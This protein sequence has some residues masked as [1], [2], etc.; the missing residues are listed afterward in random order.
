M[1]ANTRIVMPLILL[2]CVVATVIIAINARG[3]A[4]Q[5]TDALIEA[6]VVTDE[7]VDLPNLFDIPELPFELNKYPQ[8]NQLIRDYYDA[9]TLGDSEAAAQIRIDLDELGMIRIEEMA[10]YIEHY[11]DIEI[12]TKDGLTENSYVVYVCHKV[13]FREI[14]APVPGMRP[15]YVMEGPDGQLAIKINDLDEDVQQYISILNFQDNFVDLHNKVAAEFN[16]LLASNQEVKEYIAYLEARLAEDIGVILSQILNP[17]ITAEQLRDGD[18][19]V[20]GQVNGVGGQPQIVTSFLAKATAVVNIR[21]SDSETA[22][23]LGRAEIGQEFTV[24]EQ[25]GNG[26]SKISHQGRDAFIKSEYLEII[27]EVSG[28]ADSAA[29]AAAAMVKV[30]SSN[31]RIRSTAS[32]SGNVLGTANT[33]DRFELV[34]QMTNGWTQIKYGSQTGYI[35]SDFVEKE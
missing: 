23:R 21:S 12:Y 19:N 29:G 30:V 7:I 8:V 11:E 27:S 24:L 25:R 35:R 1:M 18:G 16:D 17:D 6:E 5:E 3:R 9:L 22:D 4:G 26:W 15:Y 14:D 28:A 10:K 32:T 33:G 34:E 31:V 20:D 2:I 13:K